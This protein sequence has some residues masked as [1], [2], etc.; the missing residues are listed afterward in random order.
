LDC[1][2]R[3][4]IATAL[5]ASALA[6]GG[7]ATARAAPPCPESTSASIR[8]LDLDSQVA[9]TGHSTIRVKFDDSPSPTVSNVVATVPAPAHASIKPV[10]ASAVDLVL[11]LPATGKVPLTITWDQLPH[12]FGPF[13]TTTFSTQLAVSKAAQVAPFTQ[14]SGF[15]SSVQASFNWAHTC[16]KPIVA[17]PLTI[18]MRYRVGPR[19]SARTRPPPTTPAPGAH[20]RK[21]T[22]TLASAC[23]T[24]RGQVAHAGPALVHLGKVDQGLVNVSVFRSLAGRGTFAAHMIVSFSQPGFKPLRY[25]VHGYTLL[26]AGGRVG[27]TK[28]KR[29][30]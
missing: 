15:T 20:A 23:G 13:C 26:G 6:A 16:E 29:L 27:E 24:V 30:R 10:S 3:V 21:L 14:G 12:D 5:C 17:S 1:I 2:G 4:L 18:T 19:R 28:V 22:V 8:G 11:D 9:P 25:D 7:V